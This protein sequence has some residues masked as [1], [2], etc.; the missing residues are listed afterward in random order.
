MSAHLGRPPLEGLRD[1]LSGRDVLVVESVHEHRFLTAR[2][3]E[4]LHFFDH[5]TSESGARVCRRVL[6]RLT[7]DRLLTRLQRRVGGV[8][9]GSASFVYALGSVGGRLIDGHRHRVTEPSTLFLDHTLAIAE[10]R[11]DLTL[12]ARAGRLELVSVEVEPTCW[13][14]FLGPG[15]ARELVRPDLYIVTGHGDFED[16]WFLEVDR[17]TESPAALT[18]KCR[19]YELYRRSGSEQQRHGTFPL[20]VWVTPGETR[21]RRIEAIVGRARNLKHEVF[22]CTSS[23]RLVDLLAGGAA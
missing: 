19:A 5:S 9:A 7:R 11:I 15:G 1:Q 17:G 21:A 23:A 2:Q 4:L 12:A 6:A 13:R 10:A 14:R 8:R 18:R 3:V 20:V 22:R 16:C